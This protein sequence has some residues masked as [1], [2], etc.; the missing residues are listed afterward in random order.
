MSFEQAIHLTEILLAISLIQQSLEH[1]NSASDERRL[2]IPQIL[3]SIL[4][5]VGISTKWVLLV[6]LFISFLIL[7]RFQG[8]YNGGCDRMTL[9]ILC[10]LN[11]IYFCSNHVF[12]EMA[13]IYLALQVIMS[14]FIAGLVKIIN[15]DWRSGQALKDIFHFS[16]YP[17]SEEMRSLKDKSNWHLALSWFII[18]AE[19]LFPCIF[20][21]QIFLCIFLIIA[22]SFHVANT[23]IFGF[24]RFLWIWLAAYPSVI[25][26]FARVHG[27]L[28]YL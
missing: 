12:Q 28:G 23:V 17:M 15:P 14:Y 19:L 18:A 27:S 13:F 3:F 21:N 10:C 22:F 4:L 24:N 2:F 1:L 9:L 11:F 6:L 5:L 7:Y 26:L 16:A 25:W 20:I 8:P